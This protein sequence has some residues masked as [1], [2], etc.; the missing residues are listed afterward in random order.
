MVQRGSKR[1]CESRARGP[2]GEGVGSLNSFIETRSHRNHAIRLEPFVYT[3]GIQHS[4]LE[5]DWRMHRLLNN[6]G[7]RV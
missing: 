2:H 1:V 3:K 7:F 5:F 4:I 6:I